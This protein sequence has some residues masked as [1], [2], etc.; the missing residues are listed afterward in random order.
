MLDP[1]QATWPRLDVA[2]FPEG[3]PRL[4]ALRAGFAALRARPADDPRSL[5]FQSGLLNALATPATPAERIYFTWKFLPWQRGYLYFF[6]RLLRAAAGDPAL[7]LPYWDWS[8]ELRVPAQYWG[9]GN[10][11]D[12]PNRI[13]TP[14]STLDE[15]QVSAYGL[16]TLPDFASFGGE[17]DTGGALEVGPHNYV[18]RFV[19]HD[20][21]GLATEG[22]D[23]LSFAHHAAVDRLFWIWS[24]EPTHRLPLHDPAWTE[25]RFTYYDVDARPVSLSV[26]EILALPCAYAPYVAR[27]DVLAPGAPP[28]ALDTTPVLL[29][30][31]PLSD[32][33][34][35]RLYEADSAWLRIGGITRP[36]SEPTTVRVFLVE[37]P[38]GGDTSMDSPG[39]IGS[40]TL[41]P[42]G[43]GAQA[44]ASVNLDATWHTKSLARKDA[45]IVTLVP[46]GLD[47][48]R[49]GIGPITIASV[50]LHAASA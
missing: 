43:G 29:P 2:W 19:G 38:T 46:V 18:H 32:E 17:A 30:S 24:R 39:C 37:V 48:S 8:V 25:E 21:G 50:S 33:M 5:A 3:S 9:S 27:F 12:D 44:L 4:H 7:T 16:L 47:P 26:G 28:V 49:P 36:V 10:P 11:L 15:T 22:N 45:V 42:T 35:L 31:P 34:S 23:P 41:Q 1:T 40:F 13:A 6:E 14:E 20:M